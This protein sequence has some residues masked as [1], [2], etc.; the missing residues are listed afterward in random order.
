MPKFIQVVHGI[1]KGL[2]KLRKYSMATDQTD[3]FFICLGMFEH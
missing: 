2:A 1:E 3:I